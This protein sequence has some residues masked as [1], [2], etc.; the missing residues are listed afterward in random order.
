[1]EKQL[2]T[3]SG[4]DSEQVEFKVKGLRK[5]VI[6]E[7]VSYDIDTNELVIVGDLLNKVE[8]KVIGVDLVEYVMFND[9]RCD[10]VDIEH[11]FTE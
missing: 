11:L 7:C 5:M 4:G 6:G 3:M 10:F 1:M 8:R 9:T 2:L